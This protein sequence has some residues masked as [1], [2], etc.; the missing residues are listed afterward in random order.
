M[1]RRLINNKPIQ[2]VYKRNF[3]DKF[4]SE[5]ER[6]LKLINQNLDNISKEIGNSFGYL[7]LS[8]NVLTLTICFKK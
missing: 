1:F 4:L 8:I 5:S 3:S 2:N 7:I 6:E